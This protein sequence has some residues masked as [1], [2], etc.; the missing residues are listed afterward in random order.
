MDS[1]VSV[2]AW[3]FASCLGHDDHSLL[4]NLRESRPG[5]SREH[6]FD[7]QLP[8]TLGTIKDEFSH[9]I[10]QLGD[11]DS[12]LT[13]MVCHAVDQID[14]RAS[15]FARYRPEEIGFMFGTTT[16]ATE[17]SFSRHCE[18]LQAERQ[19]FS[20]FLTS[21]HVQ[22]FMAQAVKRHFPIRGFDMTFTTACSSGAMA[23][24]EGLRAIR[25]GVVPA[26]LVGGFDVLTATT[27]FGF[28]ALQIL[29]HD[30]C[31][32]FGKNRRGINLADGGG[33][34]LLERR[35]PRDGIAVRGY[36]SGAGI[37][38]DGYHMTQP[39]PEG[40]GMI[41]AMQT[42]LADSGVDP[43]QIDFVN[44]HGTGTPANDQ[45]EA[46]SIFKTFGRKVAVAA[47]KG[48]HGHALAGSG[49]LEAII[50]LLSLSEGQFFPGRLGSEF[51]FD[52][53]VKAE[54]V[55]PVS[56][57]AAILSNSFGFG[58]SNVSLVL[59]GASRT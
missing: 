43:A 51:E 50:S 19:N 54:R 32:P 58:G 30:A 24:A 21:R 5:L 22:G 31:S 3:G 38:S 18:F 52:H 44:A 16:V 47:T 29:D 28:E 27:V 34:L 53:W 35:Q 13:R 42:A 41:A 10:D 20:K 57:D 59:Q 12:L 56:H 9:Y 2:T 17:L 26:C 25:L 14:R 8:S 6:R 23:I 11:D 33:M 40:R 48:L 1:G 4:K 39:D 7:R 55:R 37:S 45:T 46:M 15:L 36:V 49:P